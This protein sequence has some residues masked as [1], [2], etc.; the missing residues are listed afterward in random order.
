MPAHGAVTA[1]D[2][3]FSIALPDGR[4]FFSMQDSFIGDIINGK[5]PSG[6]GLF[7]RNTYF[8]YDHALGTVTRIYGANNDPNT[9]AAIPLCCPSQDK[10]YWPGHGYVD[11]DKLYKFCSLLYLADPDAGAWGM[12]VERVNVLTYQLP[13]LEFVRED[14]IPYPGADRTYEAALNDGDYVYIYAG[15][16][17]QGGLDPKVDVMVARAA[18]SNPYTDWQYYNG[19]DWSNN[20]ADAVRLEGLADVPVAALSVFKLGDKYVLLTE[21]QAL[22]V[23]DI[24]T[25]ISDTPYGPW[26]NKKTVFTADEPSNLYT[27]NATAHPQFQKDGMILASY[28]VNQNEGDFNTLFNNASFYRPRFFWVEINN[29]L[30]E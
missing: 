22:W 4:S 10:W 2:G 19:S 24:Y 27:Y 13:G 16:S 28:N 6:L 8:V 1:G 11:G 14:P 3:L 12:A 30:N 21:H 18:P 29:I 7:Y 20:A 26:R 23:G 17:I 25:F 15:V 5:F 9:S